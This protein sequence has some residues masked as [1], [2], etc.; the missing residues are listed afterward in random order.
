MQQARAWNPFSYFPG[1]AGKQT[2]Q[3]SLNFKERE[4]GKIY[5]GTHDLREPSLPMSPIASD[6]TDGSVGS[7]CRTTWE[8][9]QNSA[10]AD[11]DDVD[12]LNN[13]MK[14]VL[15]KTLLTD[16]TSTPVWT[17]PSEGK[18]E[19]LGSPVQS[20]K[21]PFKLKDTTHQQK[22]IHNPSSY[23]CTG[24]S[25]KRIARFREWRTNDCPDYIVT[26][27]LLPDKSKEIQN[28]KLDQSK[29]EKKLPQNLFSWKQ[30]DSKIIFE[31]LICHKDFERCTNLLYHMK[32]HQRQNRKH[33]KNGSMSE[34][35]C[36]LCTGTFKTQSSLG[37]HM[38]SHFNNMPGMKTF[39][40]PWCNQT[41]SRK[42]SQKRHMKNCSRP[43]YFECQM[44]RLCFF[45]DRERNAHQHNC[46][47]KD[48]MILSASKKTAKYHSF[49]WR[50]S[51]L[52]N[53]L[54]A[55]EKQM[56]LTFNSN[57]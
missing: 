19:V 53:Q 11:P 57:H 39:K 52:E 22:F 14:I 25:D 55:I 15:R 38:R 56:T 13:M 44:C 34:S 9:K 33:K 41:F 47:A 4:S 49:K 42:P 8:I 29:R 16:E 40:C 50:V 17:H 18:C 7:T 6:L 2:E 31:C 23:N 28:C 36:S 21:K 45:T 46:L 10:I 20:I 43:A 24:N 35:R 12:S 37:G 27:T 32:K 54:R 3:S 26:K 51:S 30:V 5:S 1:E 48:R